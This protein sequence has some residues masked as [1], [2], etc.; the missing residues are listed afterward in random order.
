[1]MTKSDGRRASCWPA[2]CA[3]GAFLVAVV[4]SASPLAA[5]VVSPSGE[6]AR[7][8]SGGSG[9]ADDA[10][11]TA[12]TA[13]RGVCA[14]QI[15]TQVQA[16]YDSVRNIKA[17]FRQVTRS[18]TLGGASLGN[19][20]PAVGVV[21]LAKPGKMRWA[22]ES[23]EP[24]LVVSDG[25]TLWLYDPGAREVQRLP[26]HKGYLTG[27][28]LEF[29][30]G[31]GKLVEEFEVAV[32]SCQPDAEGAVEIELVPRRPASY[33]RLG[34]RVVRDTGL[35]LET[36]VNDLFGNLTVISFSE[37]ELNIELPRDTFHFEVPDGVEVL[38][39]TDAAG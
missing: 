29:L 27:A 19:D 39:L 26:V 22:Y 33:E 35:I 15:A 24:S 17:R 7:A 34:M 37:T 32:T 1:M 25:A 6:S 31:D 10:Q 4:V 3:L 14:A 30:L 8:P 11:L 13:S 18:I 38:D 9:P 28:A 5:D 16:R 36:S 21:H 20:A 12:V 2:A 23:P